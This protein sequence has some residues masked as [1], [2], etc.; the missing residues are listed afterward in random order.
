MLLHLNGCCTVEPLRCCVL[1]QTWSC[2]FPRINRWELLS[3]SF[4]DTSNIT[5][6]LNVDTNFKI[7][8]E[9]RNSICDDLH[10]I[11]ITL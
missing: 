10:V 5:R 9:N 3:S 2:L 7:N 1:H 11:N 8:G 4:A 6:K